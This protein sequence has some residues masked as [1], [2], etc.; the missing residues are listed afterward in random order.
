MAETEEI[1]WKRLFVE[2]VAI[3]GSILLA[4]AIDTWWEER[5]EKNL[6]VEYEQRIADE[7]RGIRDLLDSQYQIVTNNIKSGNAASTFFDVDQESID[8]ELLIVSLYNMGRDP[9]EKY[10]ISTFEDLIAT[11]RLGLITDVSRRQAIQR[12]YTNLQ[13]LES[14]LRPNRAEYMAGIRGWFPQTVMDQIQAVC[15]TLRGDYPACFDVDLDIDNGAVE[16]IIENLSTDQASVAFRIRR[17]GL[18]M[19]AGVTRKTMNAID[20]ALEL[21][22]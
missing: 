22:D 13:I 15:P 1:P 2:G 16:K 3:L 20:A 4:F 17:Q 11:G 21:F 19:K 7:L 8:H 6:G 18:A 10:D 12:A 5:R 9:Q 14:M